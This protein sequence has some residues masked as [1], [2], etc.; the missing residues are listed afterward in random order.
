MNRYFVRLKDSDIRGPWT[1]KEIHERR[2]LGELPS[3]ITILE[4]LGQ[5]FGELKR[6]TSWMLMPASTEYDQ[7]AEKH[8]FE[9]AQRPILS[10]VRRWVLVIAPLVLCGLFVLGPEGNIYINGSSFSR[11]GLLGFATLTS[12][13]LAWCL[14]PP[15]DEP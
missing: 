12:L 14:F 15:K 6:S 3:G 11:T 13:I 4:A 8:A 2:A 9:E 7:E 10:P 1:L 5:S